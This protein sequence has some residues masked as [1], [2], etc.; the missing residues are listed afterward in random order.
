MRDDGL[1]FGY[2]CRGLLLSRSVTGFVGSG[3]IG[4]ALILQSDGKLIGDD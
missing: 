3:I 4:S 1:N 2:R